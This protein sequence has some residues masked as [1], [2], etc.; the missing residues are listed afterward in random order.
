MGKKQLVF[1]GTY[2]EPILFGTGKVLQG[3]GKGI[4]IYS[5]DEN[6]GKLELIRVVEG[7]RNPSYLA[8]GPENR[9]LYAVNEL[10]QCDGSNSGALS[11]FSFDKAAMSLDFLNMRLTRGTDPCHVAT[12]R[13]GKFAAVANFMSGSVAVFPV[14]DDG[15]LG[16]ASSF[17]QHHGSSVDPLRQ[18]GPHAHSITF[19]PSNNYIFVPDLG[20]DMVLAYRFD[21]ETGT[22]E[23]SEDR[24]AK[25]PPGAGPRHL[26]FHPSGRF[27]YVVNELAS[28]VI[29]Y[30]FDAKEARFLELQT[31]STLPW[32]FSGRSTCADIHISPS[33]I[34]LYA[35]NR[36]HD[37]IACF[38]ID[39]N[40][41]TLKT[42]AY[43]P[44]RG[45]TPRNFAIDREG[46]YLLAA[47]QDS[48]SIAVF[49]IDRLTGKLTYAN[50]GIEISTPVC[51]KIIDATQEF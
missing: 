4:Y 17:I 16:E 46:N 8:F 11:S 38:R 27:A 1:V 23:L 14:L 43:E 9:N 47:N 26:E 18:G 30:G 22:I 36:G 2:T 50:F 45:R 39:E 31:V 48:D 40:E 6:S 37:S 29:V 34:F 13:R 33:G 10:K 24:C 42:I 15:S 25:S 28:S 49:K 41:G 5:L 51:V 19:D 35:S 3:K 20:L 21:G 32:D 44:T 7:I 12:D